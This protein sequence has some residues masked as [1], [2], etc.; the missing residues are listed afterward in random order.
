MAIY[1]PQQLQTLPEHRF[2]LRQA[3]KN[4]GIHA[5]KR[6]APAAD[7]LGHG[8]TFGGHLARV[9]MR[10]EEE[11]LQVDLLFKIAAIG[12]AIAFLNMVLTRAG[13]DDQALLVTIAG[14]VIVLLVL[15]DEIAALFAAIRRVF[16]L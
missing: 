14:I 2:I 4:G 10:T 6:R 16:S 12:L 5:K 9:K 8:G 15:V 1:T 13:R 11:N 3:G 7:P